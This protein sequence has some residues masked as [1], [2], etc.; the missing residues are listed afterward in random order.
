M[1]RSAFVRR[2][3]VR[4][5]RGVFRY[6]TA[7][8]QITAVRPGSNERSNNKLVYI[9]FSIPQPNDY[10]TSP[11]GT[12]HALIAPTVFLD[13]VSESFLRG[14]RVLSVQ[15]FIGGKNEGL[16]PNCVALCRVRCCGAAGL[17]IGYVPRSCRRWRCR[18]RRNRSGRA[19]AGLRSRGPSLCAAP[20]VRR[21]AGHCA[22]ALHKPRPA[23]RSHLSVVAALCHH[24]QPTTI[25]LNN[26]RQTISNGSES[27]LLAKE[28]NSFKIT[29]TY[30]F[31]GSGFLLGYNKDIPNTIQSLLNA[32]LLFALPEIYKKNALQ[33]I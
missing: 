2:A 6:I 12:E 30:F 26:Y 25:T 29:L 11:I 13:H 19:K 4:L 9:F 14:I 31:F 10:F 24:M 15:E 32:F 17:G 27:P 7:I 8:G 3:A 22:L 1:S 5:L 18:R 23:A 33:F 16:A 20:G 21:S 28:G